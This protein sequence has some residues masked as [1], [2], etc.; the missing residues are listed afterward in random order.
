MGYRGRLGV[1]EILELSNEIRA[2]VGD[3]TDGHKIDE[4]A[5]RAGMTTML[6]DG[7]AKCRA[8]LTSP[9][10]IPPR[11]D[12]AV[13]SCRIFRYRALTQNGEIVHG[14][15]SAPTLAEVTRRI[16]FLPAP[17]D[18][19][20]RGQASIRLRRIPT[21]STAPGAAEVTT[22]T[23]DLALLLKAGARLDDALDLLSSDADVGRLRPHCRQTARRDFERRKPC[24][25]CYGSCRAVSAD[26]LC[27]GPRGGS[28][29]H[30]RSG[31]GYAGSGAGA[32]RTD[33]PQAHGL[34][35]VSCFRPA[36]F[37]RRHAVLYPVRAAAVFDSAAGFRRQVRQCPEHVHC[38]VG[39]S[40]C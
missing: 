10:E 12:R 2:L 36:G 4:A 27:D 25:R 20:R 8:G 40:A 30:A 1:F 13:R 33:A 37:C 32:I 14:T 28:V 39:F 16:E 38:S 21:F 17:P 29:R 7:I 34:D 6:D 15:L 23:R 11:N 19:S 35:A 5:I 9:S 22:F 18:R 3:H 31:A 24:G 26:V